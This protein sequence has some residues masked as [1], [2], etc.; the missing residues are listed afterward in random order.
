MKLLAF[1]QNFWLKR[2]R[3]NNDKKAIINTITQISDKIANATQDE[4]EF[5]R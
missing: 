3:G 5:E 4:I 1:T 2:S